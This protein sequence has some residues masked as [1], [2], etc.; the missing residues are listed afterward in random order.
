MNTIIYK[1]YMVVVAHVT[2]IFD[3]MDKDHIHIYPDYHNTK[4]LQHTCLQFYPLNL[5]CRQIF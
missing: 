3:H 2:H 5:T 1:A 4:P